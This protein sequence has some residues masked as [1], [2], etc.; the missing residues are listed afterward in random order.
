MKKY[1][2]AIVCLIYSNIK[3]LIIKIFRYQYFNYSL[4]SIC[5]PFT[6]IELDKTSKFV[7]GKKIRIR[8]GSKL[9]VRK[10][11]VMEIG[12]NTALNH[13]CIFTAYEKIQIGKN[14]QIGPNVLIYDHDHDF[15]VRDGLKNLKYK[16][17]SIIIGDNVW[18]GAN[19]I[20]LKGTK[21]GSNSVIAAGSVIKGEYSENSIIIQKRQTTIDIFEFNQR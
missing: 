20:I 2:R 3:F 6:E 19:V 5:S 1:L 18:I 17:G 10:S 13:N 14:V 16:T 8:S 7:M 11:G 4:L 21:I 12:D 9:R 15:K